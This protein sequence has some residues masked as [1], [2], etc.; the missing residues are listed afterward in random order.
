MIDGNESG[1]VKEAVTFIPITSPA[2][3]AEVSLLEEF[4]LVATLAFYYILQS[5]YRFR[6]A[7]ELRAASC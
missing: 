4:Y 6:T 2:A 3:M 5:I 1:F 7:L